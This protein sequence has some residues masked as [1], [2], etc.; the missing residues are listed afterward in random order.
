MFEK[1]T[2]YVALT[3]NIGLALLLWPLLL[4]GYIEIKIR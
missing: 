4:I 1:F 2:V 3:N